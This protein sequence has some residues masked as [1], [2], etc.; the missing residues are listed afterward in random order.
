LVREEEKSVTSMQGAPEGAT[1]SAVVAESLST[2]GYAMFALLQTGPLKQVPSL[3]QFMAQV[4]AE[5]A[6]FAQ[7]TEQAHPA[8]QGD[9]DE[10]TFGAVEVGENLNAVTQPTAAPSPTDGEEDS[11]EELPQPKNPIGTIPEYTGN[12]TLAML[13]EI[14]F[15]DE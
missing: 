6:A 15:L 10:G 2:V 11:Q 5:E 12:Q 14:S 8:Y 13:Q 3:S 9:P 4:R 1:A 7:P